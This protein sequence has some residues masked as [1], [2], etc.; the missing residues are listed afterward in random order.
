MATKQTINPIPELQPKHVDR[1]WRKVHLGS[2]DE[3]WLWTGKL[4]CSGYGS[5]TI[6]KRYF[7]AHRISF[8]IANGAIPD[9]LYVC[10]HCDNPACVNP[11]HLFAG[12]Q[13]ANLQDASRKGRMSNSAK[14]NR[15]C[16]KLTE[17]AVS[18]IRKAYSMGGVSYKQLADIWGLE[19]ST[20]GC[21]I[22][23][24]TWIS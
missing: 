2:P 5:V 1:F 20:I 18:V 21:L 10:H 19:K 8:T 14:G 22:R 24:E 4:L 23:R 13:K 6:H 7:R 11:A 15:Y 9:G 16:A 17:A 3:C 12:D